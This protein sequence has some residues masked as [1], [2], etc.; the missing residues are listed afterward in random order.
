MIKINPIKPEDLKNIH[1][2]RIEAEMCDAANQLIKQNYYG[3]TSIVK[4]KELLALYMEIK[5]ITSDDDINA[6]KKT[7]IC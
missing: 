7:N 2:D 4:R 3:G 6:E 5:G 1:I